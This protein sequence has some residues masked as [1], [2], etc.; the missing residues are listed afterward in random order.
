MFVPV[1]DIN[2]LRRLPFQWATVSLI[3]LNVL[4]YLVLATEFFAPANWYSVELALVPAEFLGRSELPS[5]AVL[6]GY[7]PLPL[8][9]AANRA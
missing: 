1:H 7:E 8:P 2:P 9:E 6:W 4:G 5:P 3:A